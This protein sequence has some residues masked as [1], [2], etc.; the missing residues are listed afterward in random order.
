VPHDHPPGKGLPDKD[1]QQILDY[2][3]KWSEGVKGVAIAQPKKGYELGYEQILAFLSLLGQHAGPTSIPESEAQTAA[4]QWLERY[5]LHELTGTLDKYKDSIKSALLYGMQGNVNPTQVSSWL[6]KVTQDASVDWRRVART[7]M[8]R[9]NAQGRL[10]ACLD[11][12]FEKVWCPP[13]AGACKSC[14]R[15][16]EGQV[17]NIEDVIHASNY[18][19]KERDW[20]PCV[21]LHPHCRHSFLP[22]HPHVY[23]AAQEQYAR[24]HAAGLTDEVLDEMFDS[25][26]QIKPGY[27]DAPE[28]AAFKSTDPYAVALSRAVTIAKGF[29]DQEQIG[30]DPLLFTSGNRLRP[31]IRSYL[32][33]WWTE[34][35]GADAQDWSHIFL[36]GGATAY[37]YLS[38]TRQEQDP[39]VDLQLIVDHAKLRD[40]RGEYLALSDPEIDAVLM[41]KLKAALVDKEIAPGVT[42]D[43]FIRPEMS[44]DEF[45]ADMRLADQSVYDVGRNEWTFRAPHEP[46][47]E[48]TNS[49]VPFMKGPGAEVAL[50]HPEW[51]LDAKR[52]R[53][54]VNTKLEGYATGTVP[55]EVIQATYK[56][57]HDARAESFRPG[58]GGHKGKGNFVWQYIVNFGRLFDLKHAAHPPKEAKTLA[59]V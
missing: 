37:S 55:F 28:L 43:G 16:L 9:A 20:V 33:D 42:L 48:V 7:E 11:E 46:H 52:A 45:M 44:V 38:E 21:P 25:S 49:D 40:V 5:A 58:G 17:F 12:G 34:T 41:V 36:T 2:L 31:E 1:W 15:L 29:F 27:A 13:H 54:L 18:G 23:N 14:K 6:Y 26:G 53:D 30:F 57:L 24:V 3:D 32:I 56:V 10:Q 8:I 19:R 4:L 35:F 39:D 47:V 22:W 50:E 59:E 51:V